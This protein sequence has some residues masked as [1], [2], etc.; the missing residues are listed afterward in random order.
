VLCVVVIALAASSCA[1]DV[2]KDY[3]DQAKLNFVGACT[4]ERSIKGSTLTVTSLAPKSTC[5]CIYN[6]IASSKHQ[7]DF[8]DLTDYEAKVS[9][10][11]AGDANAPKPPAKL[12]KA[13]TVCTPKSGPTP[14][15]TKSTT[16]TTAG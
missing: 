4:Q 8:G 16:T 2:V 9:D 3:G 10:A 6:Y 13:I 5:T 15:K 7:L 12:T 1:S 14:S 11:S